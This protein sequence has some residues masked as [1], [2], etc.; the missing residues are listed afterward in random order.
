MSQ[1]MGH[2]NFQ[3]PIFWDIYYSS[4]GIVYLFNN[5]YK[6]DWDLI[7]FACILIKIY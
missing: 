2:I 6:R 1:K 4:A 5:L 3:C 7:K